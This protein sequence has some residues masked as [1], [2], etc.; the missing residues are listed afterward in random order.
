MDIWTCFIEPFR[1]K[2]LIKCGNDGEE[3]WVYLRDI[4]DTL[5]WLYNE[6]DLRVIWIEGP[7]AESYEIVWKYRNAHIDSD[8]VFTIN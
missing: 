7:Y 5:F 8:I 3:Y 4:P 6:R 2:Q 1:E